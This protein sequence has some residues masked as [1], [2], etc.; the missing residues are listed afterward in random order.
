LIRSFLAIEIPR[1][2][3]KEIEEIQGDLRSSHA[4][5]RWVPAGNIHLTLKFFGNIE[6]AKIETIFHSIETPV[7]DTPAFSVTAGGIGAFPSQRS[8]RVVWVG[9]LS[10]ADTLITFQKSLDVELAKAGFEPEDRPFQ[11]HLTLGRMKSSRGRDDLVRKME[12]YR[13]KMF[14]EVVVE[15]LILFKSDL[16][17]SGAIYTA[18]KEIKLGTQNSIGHSA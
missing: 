18:L 16:R 3:L 14:G 7:R 12:P 4:D 17:P 6:E 5:V 8:P 10:G 2:I 15:R 9:L 1:T 11:A 13:E